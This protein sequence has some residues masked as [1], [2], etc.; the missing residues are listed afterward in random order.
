MTQ[1][2][3]ILNITPDS[4]SDGGQYNTIETALERAEQLFDDGASLIDVGAE[5]TRPGAVPLT[6]DEEWDRLEPILTELL[7]EYPGSLSVD[8]YHPENAERAL[9]MGDVTINDVTG[10]NNPEMQRVVAKHYARCIISHLPGINPQ[11]VHAGRLVASAQQVKGDLLA[12]VAE[13]EALGLNR[14][15]IILDPGIG[16]GK[17]PA[18]NEELLKFAELV[19]DFKVMIGYSRKR[20]LGENRMELEP[21]LAAGRTAIQSG[22]AYLRVH[23]VAGHAQLV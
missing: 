14:R 7:E 1:L 12:R 20:F 19:P 10:M 4:F 22:A 21:N 23:D 17:T 6:A 18:L 2:V 3:G 16:F 15:Q 9:T 11:A 5:S 13:L 8:T